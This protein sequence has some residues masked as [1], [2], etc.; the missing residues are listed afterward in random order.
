MFRPRLVASLERYATMNATRVNAPSAISKSNQDR[1]MRHGAQALAG[2]GWSVGFDRRL[3]A[4]ASGAQSPTEDRLTLSSIAASRGQDDG[5]ASENT[6]RF[7]ITRR[8]GHRSRIHRLRGQRVPA[9]RWIEATPSGR[10][11]S[12]TVPRS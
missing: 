11:R 1:H 2:L 8:P 4:A 3:L 6:I 9:S 5:Q 12:M 10:F 7:R